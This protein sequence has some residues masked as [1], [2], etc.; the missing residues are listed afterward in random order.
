ME[1]FV[2][3]L[4][5][6]MQLNEKDIYELDL[7]GTRKRFRSGETIVR[8]G[9]VDENLYIVT[10]G[11][12]REYFESEG[13]D[14]TVWFSV[15]GEVTYSVWGYVKSAPSQLNIESL[16]D[17]EAICVPKK[18]LEELFARN[19]RMANLGRRIL[20]EYAVLYEQWH[21]NRWQKNATDRYIDLMEGCE[22]C[23]SCKTSCNCHGSR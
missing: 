11:I 4:K 6:D 16:D 1:A 21:M 8:I 7:I 17:S 9:E 2:Q 15:A 20:E 13:N 10:K 19:I 14:T 3:K 23:K 12:W 22:A 18:K 5:A